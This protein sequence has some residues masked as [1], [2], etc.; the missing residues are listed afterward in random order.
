MVGRSRVIGRQRFSVSCQEGVAPLAERLLRTVEAMVSAGSVFKDGETLNCGGL[1]L[2]LR[3]RGT[4][5]W[6]GCPRIEGG[7]G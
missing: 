6:L 5:L 1:I 3:R 4:A 2:A 7:L